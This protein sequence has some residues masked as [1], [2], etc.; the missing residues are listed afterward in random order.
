MAWSAK[1]KLY[2]EWLATPRT[3][4][5]PATNKDFANKIGVTDR[6]LR[7]WKQNPKLWEKVH[8]IAKLL[9]SSHLPDIYDKLGDM[10][11]SGNLNAITTAL[12]SV[13]DLQ[14]GKDINIRAFT[15]EE[16]AAARKQSQAFR[17]ENAE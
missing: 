12:E 17:S 14:Q 11:A 7:N 13:G 10:A 5:E 8:M 16:L 9:L 3:E 2:I 1:Q 4:R 6:T 15:I